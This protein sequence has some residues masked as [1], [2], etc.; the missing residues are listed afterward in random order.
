[1]ELFLRNGLCYVITAGKNVTDILCDGSSEE[2][3][4]KYIAIFMIAQLFNAFGGTTIN[5]LAV[6]MLDENVKMKDLPFY[7]GMIISSVYIDV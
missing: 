4:G 5:L 7:S 3:N 6:P 2:S 1:M